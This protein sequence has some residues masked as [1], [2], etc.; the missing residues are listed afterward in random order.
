MN[1]RLT[2]QLDF[3]CEIDKLKTVFRRTNLIS[4]QKRLENSAEHSWHLAMYVL[5]LAEYANDKINLLNVLKM[6]LLH[7]LVEI[8]AGDTF[9]YDEQGAADKAQ[10]E[11][12][13]A[14]KLFN[15]L[16]EDQALAFRKIW[17]EFEDNQTMD[18]K[19]AHSIDRLQPVMHN[20]KSDG[21][22][23]KRHGIVRSQV[24]NKMQSVVNGSKVFADLVK[25]LLDD[26]V[27]K[28]M[29]PQQ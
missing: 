8:Y 2:Q 20:C 15:L 11:A 6:V 28:Q 3:L 25:T 23:W 22:S 1:D 5:I 13:A 17:D 14:D 10:R 12:E 24:E 4:D 26:A 9:V 18:A 29:L 19:F 7:D 16:P 21:G 27:E